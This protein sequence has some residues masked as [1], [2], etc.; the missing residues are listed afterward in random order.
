MFAVFLCSAL[1]LNAVS[2]LRMNLRMQS[3]VL[4]WLQSYD[5]DTTLR[6]K[7]QDG[8]AIATA[9][10]KKGELLI[11]IPQ[12]LT[13]DAAK[14]T[15][16]FGAQLGSITL[17]TGDVGLIALLLLAE[18]NSKDSKW[19]AYLASLPAS[20][21]GVL[22]WSEA[23][24]KELESCTTRNVAAQLSSVTTD[25][26]TLS[27]TRT[28]LLPPGTLTLETFRWAVGI[29]KSRLLYIDNKPCLAPGVDCLA[30]DPFATAEPFASSAGFFGGKVIKLLA[31]RAY[32]PG[33][34]LYMS[35][36]LKSSAE[37]LE[38]HGTVPLL[39]LADACAELSVGIEDTD[40]FPDDKT[41]VLENAGYPSRMRF[42]LEAEVG[43]DAALLQFLR[44]KF[45]EGR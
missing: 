25:F 4:Q 22:S 36:G 33:D 5:K 13:L 31:D 38:D 28:P 45:I 34:P 43:L 2:A 8:Q 16:R 9:P 21:P 3:D 18:K 39:D 29:T 23:D 17:K 32:Q 20:P 6:W 35:F 37:C 12:G 14:A 1:A 24:L 41:N 30:M 7:L 27:R 44:L 19:S 26:D 42:D 10:I 15:V 11:S 40:R